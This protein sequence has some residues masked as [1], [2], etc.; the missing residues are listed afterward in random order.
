MDSGDIDYQE[1]Y[2]SPFNFDSGVNTNY[3]YLSPRPNASPPDSPTLP[4]VDLLKAESV[5]DGE[6]VAAPEAEIL[7]EEE[8]EK[9]RKELE[10][11]EE[12]IQTLSQ[13]LSAKER[14]LADIKRKLGVTPLSELKQ[15]ISKGLHDVTSTTVYKRTSETL[16]HAGQ[17]AS[18]AFSSVGSVITRK[19]EDVKNSPTF[20]SF[21][22]KVENLKELFKGT[23]SFA[24]LLRRSPLV[25]MGPSKDKIAIGKIF[26]IVGDDLYVDFGGKFHCVCKRPEQDGEKYQKGARV[27][28]RLV[29]LELT[30][31]FLGANT[32]TTLLEADAVLLG[33]LESRETK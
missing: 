27:R 29:D 19:L 30:S 16:S 8:Q 22:E 33:L 11:I 31:R 18:A 17:K 14:H 5:P 25:Q 21:E 15:N 13:V 6:D 24:S 32:D 4:R 26:H 3:L 2:K 9:L 23:E 1:D 20:K 10:K 7:S 28:L 12:E